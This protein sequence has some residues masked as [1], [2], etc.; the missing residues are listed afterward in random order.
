MKKK[1][2]V[3]SGIFIV[4]LFCMAV[5]FYFI[6]YKQALKENQTVTFHAIITDIGANDS[7]IQVEGLETNDINSRGA[8][9]F[10]VED[11]T[12][13]EWHNT[14]I[15][16]SEFDVGDRVAVTHTGSIMESYPAKIEKVT[17]LQLLDDEK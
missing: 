17:K 9:E 14:P 4:I 3:Y 6:G 15:K 1:K 5:I 2:I 16:L 7:Y 11:D 10:S 13:L 8:F 12:K